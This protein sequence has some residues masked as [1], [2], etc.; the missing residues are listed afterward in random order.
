[1]LYVANVHLEGSPYRPS[2]RVSQMRSALQRMQQH[3]LESG[4]Q[5]S[6]CSVIICGDFNSGPR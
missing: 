6:D 2:D 3:Q 1:V 5:P 4:L